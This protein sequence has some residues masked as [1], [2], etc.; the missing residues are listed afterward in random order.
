[1]KHECGDRERRAGPGSAS[2]LA[3][4]PWFRIW[5]PIALTIGVITKDPK[6]GLQGVNLTVLVSLAVCVAFLLLIYRMR[7]EPTRWAWAP[8]IGLMLSA[9]VLYAVSPH[10]SAIGFAYAAI[11]LATWMLSLWQTIGLTA[12]GAAGTLLLA[13]LNVVGDNTAVGLSIGFIACVAGSYAI[14]ERRIARFEAATARVAQEG[15]AALAERA[16]IAREI[17]DILAHSL[18]AQIVHLEGARLLLQR[19]DDSGAALDRVERAQKLARTGLEETKRALSALRGDAPPIDEVLQSLAEEFEEV[20]ERHCAVTVEGEARRL[21][22]G[23]ALAVVR[24]AQEALTNARRHAPGADVR[25]DLRY[26]TDG[27]CELSVRNTLTEDP[28]P[29]G[30]GGGYGLVG[31]R[32][33]A[34]LLGGSLTAGAE[35]GEFRV[36]LRV[37]V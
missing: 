12:V 9:L 20:S 10:S 13:W 34:E 16:R 17:H 28:E 36:L 4:N 26:G 24:T 33:R 25:L 3:R 15:E 2:Y 5:L 30:S 22:A 21:P 27:W 6:P 29:G 35:D 31:M 1:M 23:T 32:E 14:R 11:W 7:D 19:G 37:P 8:L 18:S